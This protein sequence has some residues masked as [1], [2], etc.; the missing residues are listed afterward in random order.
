[1]MWTLSATL[2]SLFSIADFNSSCGRLANELAN[3]G[4]LITLISGPVSLEVTHKNIEQ[5]NV[6]SAQEMFEQSIKYFKSQDAAILTA[7]VADYTPKN[8]SEFKIK[9]KTDLLT[10]ELKPT[11][12]IALELGR[13]K[14]K[15]Q[16]LVGFALETNDEVENA[17]VKLETKN[18]DFIVLNS[19]NDSGAGFQFNTNKITILTRK[20]EKIPF[21]L[22]LKTLVANDIANYLVSVL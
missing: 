4:A 13:I 5:I 7:A 22:K 16:R 8:P 15:K 2:P 14:T 10:L 19:L 11:I 12:D 1:M 18:L 17:F 21:E 6:I 3:R 9:K 20:G